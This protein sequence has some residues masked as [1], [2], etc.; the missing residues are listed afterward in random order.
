M[1]KH[2]KETGQKYHSK[3]KSQIKHVD[4]EVRK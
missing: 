2:A 1:E 3:L 4:R